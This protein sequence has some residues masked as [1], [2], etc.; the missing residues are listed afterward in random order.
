MKHL[1]YSS[2]LSTEPAEPGDLT[3]STF[4]GPNVTIQFQVSAVG[5]VQEYI[6]TVK[7]EA[8]GSDIN[9]VGLVTDN[10][11]VVSA[12]FLNLT[13]GA[14]YVASMRARSYNIDSTVNTGTFR[15]Q[16]SRK[17]YPMP[18]QFTF[19]KVLTDRQTHKHTYFFLN[20][21]KAPQGWK[22]GSL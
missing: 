15:V 16:P 6:V 3:R 2:C 17:R 9:P 10:G 7:L 5:N 21:S 11:V 1:P 20:Q 12:Y 4:P 8:G 19:T 14:F 13:P 18:L 22:L